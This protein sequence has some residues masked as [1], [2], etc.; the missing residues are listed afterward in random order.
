METNEFGLTRFETRIKFHPNGEIERQ[1]YI[2]GELLDWSVDI[3]SFREA[4][5]MGSM[6]HRAIK[7]D[8]VKHF[9]NSVSEVL[10]R[11]VSMEDIV[12]ATKTGWI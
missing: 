7:E 2:G 5:K 12:K 6:Y 8:I 10:G 4:Q 9:T 11:K 3:T 1:I